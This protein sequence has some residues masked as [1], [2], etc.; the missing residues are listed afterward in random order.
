M[1]RLFAD[2][3][4]AYPRG[5]S[6]HGEIDVLAEGF[7]VLVI[8]GPSGCGKTTLLRCLAGLD[9]PRTGSIRFGAETWFDSKSGVCLSP[10]RR[11]IG[12]LFQ[13]Y[14][15]FPHLTVAENVAYGVRRESKFAK[16]RIATEA[17]THFDIAELAS[18]Y[19]RQVSGGQQQRVALARA[20]A[21]RPRLLLLDEPLAALDSFARER[22]RN[23]LRS[24][25]RTSDVPTLLVTH[26]R[27]EALALADRVALMDDGRILQVGSPNVVFH[28]PAS[29]A[30]ARVGGFETIAPVTFERV[31]SRADADYVYQG[32]M[33]QA[34]ILAQGPSNLATANTPRNL[35][36]CI[37]GERVHVV[38][39]DEPTPAGM[40]RWEGKITSATPEGIVTRVVVDCGQEILAL[41]PVAGLR[42][43]PLEPGSPVAVLVDPRDVYLAPGQ[44]AGA[45]R[46]P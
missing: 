15:L 37:R 27:V 33:G 36:A 28:R 1:N 14:A 42:T 30:A 6:I 24:R 12:F 2:F 23:E 18:R 21:C 32:R 7:S 13:E 25:L 46:L 29:M 40:N 20:L 39:R 34:S 17:L 38:F 3:C 22:S 4:L 45:P 41:V 44:P 31:E 19:P 11:G 8:V 9:R 35:Y 26:D 43:P 10:Q 16:A 5:P